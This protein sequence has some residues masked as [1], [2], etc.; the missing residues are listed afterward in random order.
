MGKKIDKVEKALDTQTMAIVENIESL[1]ADLKSLG[2]DSAGDMTDET[3][4][5]V[6]NAEFPPP[7]KDDECD[8]EEDDQKADKSIEGTN[9]ND[10]ADAKLKDDLPDQAKENLSALKSVMNTLQVLKNRA[11]KSV[12][13]ENQVFTALNELTKVVKSV[14]DRVNEQEKAIVNMLGGIGVVDEINKAYAVTKSAKNAPVQS[15]DTQ[16][17]LQEISKLQQVNKGVS[18]N[19]VGK[20]LADVRKEIADP[21]VMKALFS[22][23]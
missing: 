13:T 23:G 20:S 7:A 18:E 8:D 22:R 6:T 10:K 11:V 9:G 12:Q 3:D 2:G 1:I 15:T 4:Q 16:L 5:V 17:I 21:D 19:M 14:V